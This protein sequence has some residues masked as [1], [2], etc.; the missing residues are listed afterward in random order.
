M[1][2]TVGEGQ[3][4]CGARGSREAV[5]TEQ[6]RGGRKVHREQGQERKDTH[7]ASFLIAAS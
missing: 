6:A 2:N 4:G 3:G 5:V 1:G 7:P